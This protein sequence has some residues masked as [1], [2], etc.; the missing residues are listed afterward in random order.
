MSIIFYKMSKI[1]LRYFLFKPVYQFGTDLNSL[2]IKS[3]LKK[4]LLFF[5]K[6]T[7]NEIAKALLGII[8]DIKE[9]TKIP[10]NI[11][12]TMTVAAISIFLIAVIREQINERFKAKMF[13][14]I[15][16]DIIDVRPVCVW[17]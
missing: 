9:T 1:Q 16:I 11:W 12:T 15:P 6:K 17:F 2:V 14:P 10:T 13:M 3:N 4:I 7:F 8:I 5:W